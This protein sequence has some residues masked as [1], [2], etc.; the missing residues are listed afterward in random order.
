MTDLEASDLREMQFGL[1]G[2]HRVLRS[3]REA[4][5]SL[6]QLVV[7]P[8]E[9]PA[10]FRV[11]RG[12]HLHPGAQRQ[13]DDGAP[14]V[15]D[16]QDLRGWDVPHSEGAVHGGAQQPTSVC[17]DA[18]VGDTLLMAVEPPHERQSLT[19]SSRKHS[20]IVRFI[21]ENNKHHRTN[22]L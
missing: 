17:A 10:L 9:Y 16:L 14:E 15:E 12:E 21:S 19:S 6:K 8:Q 3:N 2:V 7:A 18:Q 22:Y 13:R 5:G 1:Q 11:G 20:S 4:P